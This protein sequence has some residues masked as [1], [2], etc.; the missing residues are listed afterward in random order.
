MSDD[1]STMARMFEINAQIFQKA[2]EGIEPEKWLVRPGNDSN[3]L[4]WL[5]GHVVVHRAIAA[6]ILAAQWSAP[7]ESLFVRG[8]KLVGPEQYPAANEILRAWKEVS[9]KLTASFANATAEVL[10][11][12]SPKDRPSLDGTIGGLVSFLCLH[13][14]YHVGQISYV[15]KFLGYGQVVG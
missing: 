7:W 5:S 4:L 10:R 12:P 3:H 9:E 11:Q 1:L 13:E 2:T 6:K 8:A 14:T 15:R